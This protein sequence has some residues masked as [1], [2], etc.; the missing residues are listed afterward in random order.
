MTHR[1]TTSD[2]QSPARREVLD[3]VAAQVPYRNDDACVFVGVDGPDGSGKTIFA[4]QLAAALRE[5]GRP[6]LRISLDDFHNTR[7]RRYRRGRESPVGFWF[8]SY[9]YGRFI[10]DVLNPLGPS[11]NGRYR[12]AAHDLVTDEVLDPPWQQAPSE[13]VV[14][15]DGLF[16]H[17][18][19]LVDRWD[20]SIFLDVP[21]ETTARRM[22]VRDNTNPDPSDPSM[23]RYVEG[24]LLYFGRCAPKDRASVVVDNSDFDAPLPV[25]RA[26]LRLPPRSPRAADI[27]SAPALQAQ[28]R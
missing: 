15:V 23:R 26:V 3:Q 10:A 2:I 9:D 20:Y 25:T 18:D 7:E 27:G 17:R 1:R 24:Q 8:D 16:L 14:I 12:A 22:A 13:C 11:G 19:E 4:D 6:V 5:T 21:F 28:H